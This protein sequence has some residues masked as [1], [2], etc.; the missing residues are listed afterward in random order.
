MR[1]LILLFNTLRFLK[2][3]QIYFRIRIK[4]TKPKIKD[5]YSGVDPNRS[6]NWEHIKLYNDS[7]NDKLEVCFLNYT[8]KIHLPIDWNNEVPSKLWVYNLHYFE[9]L[10]SKNSYK[11]A[12]LHRQLLNSWIDE[13]PIGYGNGWEPY[14]TSLRITNILKAWLGKSGIRQKTF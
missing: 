12:E 1:K 3:Q 9:D 14:P 8:K 4:L 11:K 2:W 6:A 7:I 10:L 13:N 5:V